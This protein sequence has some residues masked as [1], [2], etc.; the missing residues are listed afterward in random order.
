MRLYLKFVGEL[1]S[2]G[3]CEREVLRG[4]KSRTHLFE[5][6]KNFEMTSSVSNIKE[7]AIKECKWYL[8]IIRTVNTQRARAGC[9][10]T[11]T[12]TWESYLRHIDVKIVGKRSN[13]LIVLQSQNQSFLGDENKIYIC[14]ENVCSYKRQV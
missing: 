10:S 2:A 6:R 9:T 12:S 1:T 5:V 7:H 14:F 11:R 8:K 3:V 4:I 13:W